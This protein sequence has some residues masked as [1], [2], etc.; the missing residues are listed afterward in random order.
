MIP[1][2]PLNNFAFGSKDPHTED[3]N[4]VVARLE[5][6]K[7]EFVENEKSPR[8]SVEAVLLCHDHGH[9]HILL[10]QVAGSYFR[11]PG[12]NLRKGEDSKTGLQ[13]I[14][15]ELLGTPISSAE[16]W[17]VVEKIATWY[18]PNFDTFMYPYLPAH[19]KMPKEIKEIFMVE[20]PAKK[21]FGVPKNW[22]LIA[23]PLMEMYDNQQKYGP[24]ISSIP[25]LVSRY[26]YD[27]IN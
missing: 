1:V 8:R 2:H 23:L 10:F 7:K 22:R 27:F 25:H 18:R 3:E 13:R 11:L 19:I 15:H 26:D 16:S 14:L 9:L 12:D 17:N 21:V 24:I 5:R 20:L 6:L 4:T